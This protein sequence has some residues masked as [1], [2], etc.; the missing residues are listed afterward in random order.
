MINDSELLNHGLPLSPT[1]L[2]YYPLIE[3][4][5][6]SQNGEKSLLEFFTARQLA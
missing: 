4:F 6:W 2:P 1:F 5:L 3:A